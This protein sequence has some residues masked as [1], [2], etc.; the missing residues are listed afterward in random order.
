MKPTYSI[1]AATEKDVPE[2]LRLV[3]SAYRGDSSRA[4]WTTEADLLDGTRT[5]EASLLDMIQHPRATVLVCKDAAGLL[6]G[7]V[8]LEEVGKSLYLGMLTVL[9]HLQSGGIGKQL[10]RVAEESARTKKCT[11]IQMTVISARAELIAWYERHGYY[12]TGETQP[13]PTEER[14]GIPK[15]RLEFVVMKKQI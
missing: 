5:D 12:K 15:Q 10:L 1:S 8:Y 13:F 4:G 14:F 9:P 7:C 6:A 2:L 3:N 11:T